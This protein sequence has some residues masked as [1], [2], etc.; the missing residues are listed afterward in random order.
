MCC[1]GGAPGKVTAAEQHI[2]VRLA[3]QEPGALLSLLAGLLAPVVAGA[4][5]PVATPAPEVVRRPGDDTYLITED[6]FSYRARN[7]PY[8]EQKVLRCRVNAARAHKQGH[9]DAARR[10]RQQADR[11]ERKLGATL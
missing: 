5:L 11:L 9:L 6:E 10:Y 7:M 3:Q 1:A 2:V 4:A 8:E